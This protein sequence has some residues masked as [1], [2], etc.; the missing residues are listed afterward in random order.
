MASKQKPG[1]ERRKPK[2]AKTAGKGVP[3]ADFEANIIRKG[4]R[5]SQWGAA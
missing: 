2:K 3:P 5:V 1:K 4:W